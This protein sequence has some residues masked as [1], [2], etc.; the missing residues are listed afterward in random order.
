MTAPKAPASVISRRPPVD[1]T[2]E[3]TNRPPASTR[4][5]S[6]RGPSS[7][8]KVTPVTTS[9]PGYTNDSAL[10]FMGRKVAANTV[11]MTATEN[12]NAEVSPGVGARTVTTTPLEPT[13]QPTRM[14]RRST[15]S[16]S[17]SRDVQSNFWS[18]VRLKRLGR[19]LVT[20]SEL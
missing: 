7:A 20:R 5:A 10:S 4:N 14:M 16:V 1:I 17:P 15:D 19:E 8:I 2:N 18:Q 9:A 12:S 3:P 6:A 11:T 13:T